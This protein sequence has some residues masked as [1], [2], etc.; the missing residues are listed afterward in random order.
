MTALHRNSVFWWL[1]VIVLAGVALFII[2]SVVGMLVLGL[3]G[4]YAT[5]PICH[6]YGT[7]VESNWLAAALTVVTVLLPVFALSIYAV[8][9]V[10][11]QIQR[12]SSTRA[13]SP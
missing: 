9:R 10:F 12:L 2:Y 11:Q 6:R 4:Y 1:Y 13:S 7:V 5:R 8:V 3:F